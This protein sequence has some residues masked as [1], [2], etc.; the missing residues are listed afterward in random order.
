MEYLPLDIKR[1]YILPELNIIDIVNLHKAT[2]NILGKNVY[3]WEELYQRDISIRL[4]EN[5][6]NIKET[7]LDIGD[8]LSTLLNFLSP[9]D[10]LVYTTRYGYEQIIRWLLDRYMGLLD[11][12]I[13]NEEIM[14]AIY[15]NN[16]LVVRVF[17]EPKY[18]LTSSPAFN[19]SLLT[20]A[21]RNRS[22]PMMK[23]IYNS[24]VSYNIHIILTE[25][26]KSQD[27]EVMRLA[28]NQVGGNGAPLAHLIL[29]IINNR[30]LT[31]DDEYRLEVLSQ[32][33]PEATKILE[34]L[35]I[36]KRIVWKSNITL[37]FVF[38][39][40]YYIINYDYYKVRKVLAILLPFPFH[41]II[42]YDFI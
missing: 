22:I 15:N 34:V 42:I 18:Q 11:R 40:Y 29:N 16:I 32:E 12:N 8:H 3:I 4:P 7:Y 20:V 17:L 39:I 28:S 41:L 19:G 14:N 26:I 23:T 36:L 2:P 35:C 6:S 27:I 31:G 21:I 5:L 33:D 10:A 9:N 25:A 13:I 1:N 37:L 30:D 24:G 38:I